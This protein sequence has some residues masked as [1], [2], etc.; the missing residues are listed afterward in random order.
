MTRFGHRQLEYFIAVANA[1][2]FRRA[3]EALYVSQPSLSTQIGAMERELGAPLFYRH[4]RGVNLTP[5]GRVLL[6]EALTTVAAADRAYRLARMAADGSA[7]E[8]KFA[9]VT[10]IAAGLVPRALEQWRISRPGALV[11][12]SEFRNPIALEQSVRDGHFDF[13][14]GPKPGTPFAH[15]QLLGEE[16]F[17]VLL[18]REDPLLKERQLSLSTLSNRRW[19]LFTPDNGIYRVHQ[20]IF[21]RENLLIEGTATTSQ[22]DVAVNLAAAG[23]GPT[24][25][26]SNVVPEHLKPYMRSFHNAYLR[27]VFAYSPDVLDPLSSSFLT[28]L[29]AVITIDGTV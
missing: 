2:S 11:S 20:S 16:E 19:V 4:A 3:A 7:G 13:G 15:M 17:V 1:G 27:E 8:L 24:I 23:L 28:E 22:T 6:R 10:S 14:I 5:V 26:P 29:G 25:V 21:A 9:T 18:P 12:I